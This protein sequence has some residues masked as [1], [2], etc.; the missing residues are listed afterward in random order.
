MTIEGYD[1]LGKDGADGIRY[2]WKIN[3]SSNY[4]ES[5]AFV[6][7]TKA[8]ESD[9]C[10][11]TTSV[12]SGC[13][14]RSEGIPC[15]FC[16]TGNR[17]PFSRLLTAK[18]IALQNVFMVLTDIECDNH[19]ELRSKE[20]EFAYMGQG[21]PG[22]S[23]SQM[24]YAIE[25][26]NDVMRKLNQKVYRHI[27]A[28]CGMPEAIRQYRNDINN[29]YFSERVTLHLSLHSVT[30][31]C[32]VMPIN[33][34]YPIEEVITEV[35]KI[36]S[37]SGEKPCVGILLFNHFTKKNVIEDYSND[38]NEIKKIMSILNP[39]LVR[40]SFCEYNPIF[41]DEKNEVYS[42]KQTKEIIRIAHEYG[43]ET[44]LFSSYGREKKT[45]CGMLG[46]KE[47]DVSA[48]SKWKLLEQKATQLVEESMEVL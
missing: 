14:L 2:A 35:E 1:L 19:P 28:T 10:G 7:K 30:E 26:T 29:K 18:E 45:A 17:L 16:A 46:G 39:K 31:R 36:Y 22:F 21:E 15:S 48:S 40:L 47:P 13:I 4:V 41:Q 9:I 8:I 37:I 32:K 33:N 42:E 12:S 6:N 43:F 24:R 44:K 27:F 38:I 5:A 20:R 11:Y 23:Y 34:I 3:G 25:I